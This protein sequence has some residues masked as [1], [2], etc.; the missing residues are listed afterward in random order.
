MGSPRVFPD[1]LTGHEPES[2]TLTRSSGTLSP[3][4]GEG[5]HGLC[6]E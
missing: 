4:G 3:T 1:V 2:Y 6:K 5:S